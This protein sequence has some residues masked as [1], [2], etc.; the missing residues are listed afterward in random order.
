MGAWNIASTMPWSAPRKALLS[1]AVARRCPAATHDAVEHASDER[2]GR[3]HGQPL[4]LHDERAGGSRGICLP[5]GR[6]GVSRRG[7]MRARIDQCVEIRGRLTM[8]ASSGWATG[9]RMM[10]IRKRA[11]AVSA[12][13]APPSTR[14]LLGR[15]HARLA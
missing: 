10:S 8:L 11:E 12:L 5:R 9:T 13:A 14:Q 7:A 6:C 2:W 4:K 1:A 3:D 15:T